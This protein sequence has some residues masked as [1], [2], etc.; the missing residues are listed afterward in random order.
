MTPIDDMN[1]VV[2]GI[3]SQMPNAVVADL[4]ACDGGTARQMF[5][6]LPNAPARFLVVE[7]DPR[8]LDMIRAAALPACVEVVPCAIGKEDGW[9]ILH[10]S[11]SDTQKG[12]GGMWSV[13]STMRKPKRTLDL[14]PFIKYRNDVKVRVRGLDSL[15]S[16]M[17]ING[18]DILW[19]DIEGSEG[20]MIEGG[21]AT[22]A[23]TKYLFIEK[24]ADELYEGMATRDKILDLLIDWVIVGEWEY[25]ILLRNASVK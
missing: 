23:R 12:P 8:N 19:C 21:R 2:R 15:C 11:E 1:S 16:E 17:G 9:G 7:P 10:Q 4:G 24:W 13:S 25:D 14:F 22:L 5:S 20:D 3:A 18:F 6:W